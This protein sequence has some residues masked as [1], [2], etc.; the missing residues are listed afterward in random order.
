MTNDP[1]IKPLTD[2]SVTAMVDHNYDP[3][4]SG[5]ADRAYNESVLFLARWDALQAYWRQAAAETAEA[6]ATEFMRRPEAE[7]APV[8]MILFCPNCGLQ[9]IDKAERHEPDCAAMRTALSENG[10]HAICVCNVWSNPPHRS[11]LCGYCNH[12]WRPADVPTNGVLEIK[13]RGT[14]DSAPILRQIKPVNRFR[15]QWRHTARG[16]LYV[17]LGRGEFQSSKTNL[18]GAGIKGDALKEGARLVAYQ[19][20]DNR[21]WFRCESEFD[22][23]RFEKL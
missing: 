18:I 20:D 16:T 6:S 23:G 19:G 11:H 15:P 8:D 7:Q 1:R 3:H 9:H 14:S 12:V 2:A 4:Y 17:E 22:D 21:V 10:T 5:I 13:S